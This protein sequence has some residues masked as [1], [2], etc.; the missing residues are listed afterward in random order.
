MVR[1]SKMLLLCA[2][3]A[4][5]GV[6]VRQN[7]KV[8]Q[9][10]SLANV[11]EKI[12][13]LIQ[14]NDLNGAQSAALG[15]IRMLA[16]NTPGQPEAL[17]RALTDVIAEIEA[18][19]DTKITAGF[20]ATQAAVA[21]AI[22]NLEAATSSALTQKANADQA[23]QTWF[24]CIGDEKL[25]REDFEAA[26][27]AE[28]AANV[29][30]VKPCADQ[31]GS[32]MFESSPQVPVF[33]CDF[34]DGD[35][36]NKQLDA[37]T[38]MVNNMVDTLAADAA[39]ATQTWTNYKNACDSANAHAEDMKQA[40]GGADAAWLAKREMCQTKHEDRQVSV[41]SFGSALQTKCEKVDAYRHLIEEVDAVNGGPNSEP[42]RQ[43]EW[44]TT[45]VTKCMLQ[46]VIDGIDLDGQSLAACE[47]TVDYPVSV[48]QFNKMQ[49]EF[50]TQTSENSFTCNEHTVT[51]NTGETWNVPA[52]FAPASLEYTNEPF[53]PEVTLAVG[54][55]AFAFCSPACVGKG[56]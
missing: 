29:A 44:K 33:A 31:E 32:K 35:S 19:V 7:L 30:I 27:V 36:C 54:T 17:N 1:V 42:D 55:P 15:N 25:K 26:V 14:A 4:R 13:A 37:Y 51:F 38:A 10:G 18:N 9:S 23:D 45:Q 16:A 6:A 12:G 52:G 40:R 46:K 20:A 22:K 47:L 56:C 50:S 48:G 39:E 2:V 41:C 5:V 43:A 49:S 11:M 28:D 53:R 3:N 21:T 8:S 24:A 34:S